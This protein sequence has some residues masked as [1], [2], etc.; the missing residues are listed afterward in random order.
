MKKYTKKL[1][2]IALAVVATAALTVAAFAAE[3]ASAPNFSDKPAQSTNVTTGTLN[4]AIDDAIENDDGVA[5]AT[6]EA[7]STNNITLSANVMKALADKGNVILSIQT[8]EVTIEVDAST[9]VNTKKVNLSMDVRNTESKTVIDFR[10][11]SEFGC[12]V[13]VIV[14]NC[15]LSE[16][17]L[18]KA[19][20][21][22]NG[23]DTGPVEINE[24]GLPVITAVKGGKY[25]IK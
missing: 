21:Y 8:G 3:Y 22:F 6:I 7:A 4:D 15:S 11:S 12:E 10:S 18:E 23:E 1:T 9:I 13:K 16:N 17:Q 24:D 25:E 2:C 5:V 19:H 20:I 14:N